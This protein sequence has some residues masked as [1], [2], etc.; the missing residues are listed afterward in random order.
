MRSRTTL[1]RRSV[2]PNKWLP[3]LAAILALG[4]ASALMADE[5]SAVE[6]FE[7]TSPPTAQDTAQSAPDSIPTAVVGSVDVDTA[8]GE[9]ET[10][11]GAGSS[12]HGDDNVTSGLRFSFNGVPW[13]DVIRWIAD[14]SE[15]ALHVGD[16]PPGSFTYSDNTEYSPADA[17]DRI[18]LFLIAEGFTLVRSGDL[19]SVINLADPRSLQQLDVLAKQIP[20]ES[21]DSIEGNHEVVK[22]MFPLG[23][24]D[25]DDAVDELSALKLMSSPTVLSKT[26]Q[27]IITDTVAKLR[28]VRSVLAAFEPDLMD[29]VAVVKNFALKHVSAEDVLLVARPHLGLATGEMIGIDVSLSSDLQGKHIFVTGIEDKVDLIQRLVEAIDQP[30]ARSDGAGDTRLLRSH[31]V[32]GG[33]VDTVYNILQTILHGESVRISIDETSSSIVAL[34]SPSVHKEIEETVAQ[35]Q[36]SDAA[37]EVIPLVNTDPYF[38]ITLLE[39]ML[40]LPGPYDDADPDAPKIDGDPGNRRLFVRGKQHQID[41]IKK[42]VAGL[43]SSATGGVSGPGAPDGDDLTRLLPLKGRRAES[44]LETAAQFWRSPNSVIVYPTPD[45]VLENVIERV[46]GQESDTSGRDWSESGSPRQ[47]VELPT[48]GQSPESKSPRRSNAP[49]ELTVV[50][51]SRVPPIRCQL[52][53]RGILLQSDDIEALDRFES[54]LRLIAGP[55]DALPS[56]PIVF[57]LQHAKPA[58][59]LR[60]LGELL[61]GGEAAGDGEA[62]TLVNGYV[63]GG[64]SGSLLGSMVSAQDGTTTMMSGSITVVA[65]SRLNRLIAQGTQDDL[66]RIASYLKIIDKDSSI[67]SIETYGRAQVIE[68]QNSKADDVADAIRQAFVGRVAEEKGKAAQAGATTLKADSAAARAVA[69][70]DG[71]T[72]RKE[73]PKVAAADLEPKMTVAVHEASNSLIVTAPDALFKEVEALVEH[74]DARGEQAVEVVTPLNSE[75]FGML[76]QHLASEDPQSGPIRSSVTTSSRSTRS[77][78]NG[79]GR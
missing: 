53:D 58:D 47:P 36:A 13:R 60:M 16:L 35:V 76:L 3:V 41:Q 20:L 12:D 2:S 5:P 63:A 72:S 6:A 64:K 45:S 73:E 77:T 57:Y 33:N 55:T 34:A 29:N 66:Q 62:G 10:E 52:T 9:L 23:Q 54:H 48:G 50:S 49:R 46:P 79:R 24:I 31:F 39:Q 21:L 38:V 25:S 71:K 74:I 28:N 26:N 15:M 67:T 70:R 32:T 78:S 68:L 8:A 44:L 56:R 27:L 37:F 75:L 42:I 30:E 17:I 59:A 61:D 11:P 69:A 65:D 7:K 18:N 19:L 51:N 1:S 43:E 4:P 14:E 22:C 40:N